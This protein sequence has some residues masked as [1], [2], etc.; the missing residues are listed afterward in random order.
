[1]IGFLHCAAYL[2]G[3]SMITPVENGE[4]HAL[5]APCLQN[6]GAQARQVL[7]HEPRSVLGSI[8]QPET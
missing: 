7:L 5:C 6:F 3:A 4:G 1:M 2:L 8:S